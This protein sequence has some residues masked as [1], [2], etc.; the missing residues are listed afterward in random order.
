MALIKYPECG[1]DISDRAVSCPNCGCPT[2][3]KKPRELSED[4]KPEMFNCTECGRP[5]PVTIEKCIYC[6]KIYDIQKEMEKESIKNTGRTGK[7][8]LCCPRCHCTSVNVKNDIPFLKKVADIFAYGTVSPMT[9][10][11][12]R[13]GMIYVCNSC[14]YSWKDGE[15]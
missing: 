9:K 11:Q 12:Y 4:E 7:K 1:K 2:V 14:N 6:G 15:A 3:E 8:N 5:L 10:S 13:S